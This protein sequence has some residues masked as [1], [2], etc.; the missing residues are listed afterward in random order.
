[1]STLVGGAAVEASIVNGRLC[2]GGEMVKDLL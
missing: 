1:V 2:V